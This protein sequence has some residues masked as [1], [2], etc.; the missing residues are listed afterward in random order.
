MMKTFSAT[1]VHNNQLYAITFMARDFDDARERLAAIGRGSVDGKVGAIIPAW[2]V[3]FGLPGL[4]YG[5]ALVWLRNA[6]Y[7]LC[8]R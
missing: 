3:Q 1:Y 2:M 4:W 5:S 6:W 8:G 7:S